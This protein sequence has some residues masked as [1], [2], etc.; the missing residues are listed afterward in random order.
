MP[1]FERSFVVFRAFKAQ[2]ASAVEPRI[3]Q[4]ST[5]MIKTTV[6]ILYLHMS[7]YI[8]QVAQLMHAVT[9]RRTCK[10]IQEVVYLITCFPRARF[11]P[12]VAISHRLL[13]H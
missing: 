9:A 2:G 12:F 8:A 5:P 7:L 3:R 6:A 10:I 1:P 11:A 13:T 4:S